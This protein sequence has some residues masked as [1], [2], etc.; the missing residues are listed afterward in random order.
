VTPEEKEATL[1]RW[2]DRILS[3]RNTAH[4]LE[5]LAAWRCPARPFRSNIALEGTVLMS[6]SSPT[7][8]DLL[9]LAAGAILTG[10]A[11]HAFQPSRPLLLVY[12]TRCGSTGE[13]A[14][15]VAQDL[16]ARGFAVDL[17]RADKTVSAAHYGNVVVGGA[18][19][20]GKWL[21]EAVDFVK[22]N[23]AALKQKPTA[24]F[25]VH[26]LNTGADEKSREARLSYLAPARALIQPAAEIYFAGKI[27]QSR[28]SFTDRL[29]CKVFKARNGD[30]RDWPA[31]HG[32]AQGV[33]AVK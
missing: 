2:A 6:V 10:P 16:K 31:I 26:M 7:R 20:Y 18:V 4:R 21:P 28:M 19:R 25:A 3:G 33:F 17:R 5:R 8:R 23:Q 24:F 30:F 13:I 9:E 27:D 22:R 11:L 29:M 1:R 12:A 32:W 15:Q 14:R